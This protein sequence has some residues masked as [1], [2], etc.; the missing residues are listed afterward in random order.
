MTDPTDNVNHPSHYTAADN[1]IEC[2]DAIIGALGREGAEAYCTGC[3]M[4]YMWRY[5]RKGGSEDIKKA[6][7]YLECLVELRDIRGAK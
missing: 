7:W 2:I 6:I 4:K 5:N 3:A 1:G